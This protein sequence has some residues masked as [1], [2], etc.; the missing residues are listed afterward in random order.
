MQRVL[1]V[2]VVIAVLTGLTACGGDASVSSFDTKAPVVFAAYNRSGDLT[3]QVDFPSGVRTI[4]IFDDCTAGD[5]DIEIEVSGVGGGSGP[6]SETRSKSSR[7]TLTMPPGK[8]VKPGRHTVT[9]KLE[10]KAA[11]DVKWSAAVTAS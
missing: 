1:S 9:V 3:R 10:G 4:T 11:D 7:V 5:A 6:C 2:F 8:T